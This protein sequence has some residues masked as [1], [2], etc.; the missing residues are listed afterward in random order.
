[1]APCGMEDLPD[2]LLVMIF[3]HLENEELALN[4]RNVC[5]RWKKLADSEVLWENYI[6]DSYPLATKNV[7]E[8]IQNMPS[9]K[10]YYNEIEIEGHEEVFHALA[11]NSKLLKDLS[12]PRITL[13]LLSLKTLFDNLPNLESLAFSI[14][15]ENALSTE[16]IGHMD[17][18]KELT[19]F[20]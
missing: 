3:S 8:L 11:T 4:A 14:S 12:V 1:M 10:K 2:E 16:I 13:P 7:V 6:L 20:N 19:L 17:T 5:R 9:L 18:I 15:G